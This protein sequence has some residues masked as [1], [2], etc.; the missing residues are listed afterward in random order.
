MPASKKDMILK[1]SFLANQNAE[2]KDNLEI[3][4]NELYEKQKTILNL[5]LAL[6]ELRFNFQS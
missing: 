2:M 3:N 6:N 1:N 5:E 4:R